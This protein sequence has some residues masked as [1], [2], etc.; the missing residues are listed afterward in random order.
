MIHFN[1]WCVGYMSLQ[2]Q[3]NCVPEKTV[4][5]KFPNSPINTNLNTNLIK[6]KP[7]C[8]NEQYKVKRIKSIRKEI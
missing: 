5:I 6:Q 7:I 1:D 4:L 2:V 3:N 8:K